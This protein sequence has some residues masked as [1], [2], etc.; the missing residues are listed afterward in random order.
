MQDI[1]TK[2]SGVRLVIFD[3]D[4]V[5]TDGSLFLGDDGQEYKAFNSRDGHGMKM[6]QK[7]GVLIG[8]ITGRTSEVV[9]IRMES[10][11]IEHVYQGKQDKLPAYEELRDKLGL[12]DGQVAYVGDDVVDLPIMRRVG[13]A[14]AVN[15]AH[16]FVVQ[17]AHWQT[18][19]AGGRGAGRD[20]CEMVLE[21]QGNLQAELESY[22]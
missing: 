1:Y 16:P 14:I 12:E 7:S 15:D 4:G 5:L 11:G 20:V 18:P 6:L 21:A 2:A 19:H 9:R 22:L 3:V 10:L 17:H 13:L 8:I